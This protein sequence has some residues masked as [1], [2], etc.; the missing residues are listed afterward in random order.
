MLKNINA[1][2]LNSIINKAVNDFINNGIG[3]RLKTIYRT[4]HVIR[5]LSEIG[6]RTYRYI[7]SKNN[8]Y[9]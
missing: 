4:Y 3:K 6:K 8:Y 7:S 5:I 9:Y 2:K 1:N